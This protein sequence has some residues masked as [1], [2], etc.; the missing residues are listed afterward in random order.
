[1]I[2]RGDCTFT[3]VGFC[4]FQWM[5]IHL[6]KPL[7]LVVTALYLQL[8]VVLI[9]QLIVGHYWE[10]MLQCVDLSRVSCLSFAF[11]IHKMCV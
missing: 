3:R 10:L 4:V 8:P 1:M 7:S 11:L 6:T 9:E 5:Q 2:V